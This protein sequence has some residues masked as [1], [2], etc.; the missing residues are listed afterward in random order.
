MA[1]K[2]RIRDMMLLGLAF[3]GDLHG[4]FFPSW[5]V[6][7][8]KVMGFLPEDYKVSNYLKT[9]N[10]M[11]KTD[12]VEKVIEKGVV[13]LRLGKEGK[14]RLVRNFS[15]FK[16]ANESWDGYWRLAFYD[17]PENKKSSR[18]ALQKK[19]VN[20]GF[21]KLQ[22]SVYV[23]PYN[24]VDDLREYLEI[25]GLTDHV[26]V[27]ASKRL[28]AGNERILAEKIWSLSKLNEQ[29]SDWLNSPALQTY[30][31]YL[32]ILQQD[33]CLPKELLPDDWMGDKAKQKLK[34]IINGQL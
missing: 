24:L 23:S 22:E 14:G 18:I 33:P 19:L 15:L 31:N 21:G 5:K 13:Y 11:L 2:L 20:I 29:Y 3:A 10:R 30:E 34:T 26:F 1:K 8:K 12:E 7:Y 4:E 25:T 9:V 27:S 32:E 28:L 6:E 17:I 16:L